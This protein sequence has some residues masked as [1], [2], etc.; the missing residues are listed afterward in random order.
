MKELLTTL[1]EKIMTI[2]NP[3]KATMDFNSN[4]TG[5]AIGKT[6][7]IENCLEVDWDLKVNGQL[8]P[9]EITANTDLNTI[10][11]PGIYVCY[12]NATAE[13]L[14]N[15]PA[16]AAFSLEVLRT[17]SGGGTLN[18]VVQRLTTYNPSGSYEYRRVVYSGSW[19]TWAMLADFVVEQG[20]ATKSGSTWT[21]RKWNSGIA[22]C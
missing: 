15:C 12:L 19:S 20:T 13:T 1:I 10:V 5:I 4:H 18:N 14:I 11:E 22:E 3:I 21:Y 17:S 16:N 2:L 9:R 7:E 6:S 8:I